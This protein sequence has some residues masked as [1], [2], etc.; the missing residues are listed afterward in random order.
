LI[1]CARQQAT[2]P[3]H[4]RRLLGAASNTRGLPEPAW[5][6]LLDLAA[7]VVAAASET[8]VEAKIRML[9]R[10][11][12][13]GALAADDA[14]VDE[15]RFLVNTLADLEAPHI[16]VLHQ[17]SIEHEGYD[18]P[19]SAE[20]RRRAYGWSTGDLSKQLPGMGLVLRPVLSALASLELIRDTA[21]GSLD[22][23]PGEAER[24][25]VTDFGM[26]RLVILEEHGHEDPDDVQ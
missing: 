22:Y 26:Q 4:L 25:I 7:A 2:A 16:R 3:T 13:T 23:V 24:W 19:Q 1:A 10:A 9:G 12:A 5:D 14:V 15:Q 21:V 6:L 20:G 8:M 17:L 18:S 11:L